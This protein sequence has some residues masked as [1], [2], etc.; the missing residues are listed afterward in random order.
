MK[1]FHLLY[2]FLFFLFT[3]SAFGQKMEVFGR[4][5]D[6]TDILLEGAT[7]IF[8]NREQSKKNYTITDA[9]GQFRIS[10]DEDMRYLK[11]SYIGY[12]AFELVIDDVSESLT[13]VLQRSSELLNEI[14]LDYKPKTFLV[15]KDIVTINV[16]EYLDG[17]EYKMADVLKKIPGIS[18]E[19]KKVLVQGKEI[20]KILVEGDLFFK[21]NTSFAIENI[22]AE[23]IKAIEVIDNYNEVSFLSSLKHT[24]DAAINVKLK[25]DK[26]SFD[27]GELSLGYGNDNFNNGQANYINYNSQ[28]QLAIV[29]ATN[30]VSEALDNVVDLLADAPTENQSANTY[31]FE[32]RYVNK[33]YKENIQHG[34][35]TSLK[36]QITPLSTFN[37]T[38]L[39]KNYKTQE[40]KQTKSTFLN[41]VNPYLTQSSYNR[42]LKGNDFLVDFNYSYEKKGQEKLVFNSVS[43][44]NKSASDLSFQSA[45][46]NTLLSINDDRELHKWFWFGDLSYSKNFSNK[47]TGNFSLNHQL[48]DA[49]DNLSLL[50]NEVLFPNYFPSKILDEDSD[51]YSVITNFYTEM[52]YT[53]SSRFIFDLKING[54]IN[55]AKIDAET[56][57]PDE[58]VPIR[59]MDRMVV[60]HHHGS[61]GL[62]FSKKLFSIYSSFNVNYFDTG[63]IHKIYATPNIRVSYKKNFEKEITF[64]YNYK[65]QPPN[66]F[67]LSTFSTLYNY[68]TLIAGNP[69]LEPEKYHLI[70]LNV[71]L[72]DFSTGLTFYAKAEIKKYETFLVSV[73]KLT[74]ERNELTFRSIDSN[75]KEI[76]VHAV[77]GKVF[78]KFKI[79][80]SP[81]L[82]VS[83]TPQIVEN[84]IFESDNTRFRFRINAE[85]LLKD[86]P[87][88]YLGYTH[89]QISYKTDFFQS[90]DNISQFAFKLFQNSGRFEYDLNYTFSKPSKSFLNDT[91]QLRFKLQYQLNKSGW[92]VYVRGENLL[93]D[94]YVSSWFV[95][96]VAIT[97]ERIS[98]IPRHIL[99]GFS[100]KF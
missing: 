77:L 55:R 59:N 86:F 99:L 57:G 39:F 8:T 83:K 41:P 100:F 13:V 45:R 12:E 64:Q 94:E 90:E 97:E 95:S 2:V 31:L 33:E 43:H 81:L 85:T 51:R 6:E 10:L 5:M 68:T 91:H 61:A 74:Q 14:V 24:D 22:P 52:F 58:D 48:S 32:S 16:A 82:N 23:V 46:Q 75:R 19:G 11:V 60:N 28:T 20:N 18:I 67:Y 17:N 47:F 21:G 29:G 9:R 65:V 70:N 30:N 4:V 35:G 66:P 34:I 53:L 93:D 3:L 96:D 54:N 78:K 40:E 79:N 71:Y 26:K 84:T 98:R 15:Q 76:R 69:L 56:T 1:R 36:H 38:P 27:F 7:I 42:K 25:E 87:N 37:I 62:S 88:I 89:T 44:L 49:T 92:S 80:L 50:S 63:N 73:N 72:S